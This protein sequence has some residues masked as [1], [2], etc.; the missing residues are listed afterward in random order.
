MTEWQTIKTAP[1]DG[2]R[3][4]I[5]GTY[6]W[7]DYKDRREKGIVTVYWEKYDIWDNK[8]V[9]GRWRLIST[10]PY[11]DYAQPTHWMPL[12]GRPKP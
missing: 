9:K 2:T 3:I 6:Q 8:S 12:P 1:K 7:E 4:L 11:T 5:F 10:N